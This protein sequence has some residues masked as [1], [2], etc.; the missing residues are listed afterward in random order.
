MKFA[1]TIAAVLVFAAS[2]AAAQ[3]PPLLSPAEF[4]ARMQSRLP[5]TTPS[6]G[7]IVAISAEGNT[8]VWRVEVQDSMIEGKDPGSITR[9]MQRGWCE[10]QI[11]PRYFAEGYS[12]QVEYYSKKFPVRRSGLITSC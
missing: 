11:A 8:L 7:K 6:G 2:A 10:N 5:L 4:A 1:G 9:A 3:S 12:L